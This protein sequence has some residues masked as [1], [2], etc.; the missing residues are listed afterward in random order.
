MLRVCDAFVGETGPAAVT[1][2]DSP[3]PSMHQVEALV[4]LLEGQR[5]RHKFIDLELLVHVVLHQPGD[6]V[7]TLVA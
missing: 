5:V 7:Y 3:F 2:G 6:T 1:D 4:D